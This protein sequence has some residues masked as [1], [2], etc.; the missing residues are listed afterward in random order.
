MSYEL[1]GNEEFELVRRHH[2][3]LIEI[4]KLEL[5]VEEIRNTCPAESQTALLQPIEQ[6]LQELGQVL[7]NLRT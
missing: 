1:I 5:K 4:G 3:T 2:D 6:H 7:A